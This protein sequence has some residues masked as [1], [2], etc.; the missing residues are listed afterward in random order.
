MDYLEAL[1]QAQAQIAAQLEAEPDAALR[2]YAVR[3]KTRTEE[4][5]EGTGETARG[6]GDAKENG[7]AAASE[8]AENDGAAALLRELARLDAIQARAAGITMRMESERQMQQ[9]QQSQS[10]QPSQMRPGRYE[11]GLNGRTV[12]TLESTGLAGAQTQWT[13]GEISRYF[14]RDARRYGG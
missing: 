9:A 13:M 12:Q 1:L 3:R 11:G 7:A 8:T 5:A 14:E 4:N 10:V 2:Q 6:Y